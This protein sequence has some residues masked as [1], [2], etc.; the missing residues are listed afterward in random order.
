[1]CPW[2]DLTVNLD[3]KLKEDEAYIHINH[4]PKDMYEYFVR[5]GFIE[6]LN[7]YRQSGFVVFPLCRLN[8]QKFREF[9]IALCITDIHWDT[10][11]D[12]G[13][14][15]EVELPTEVTVPYSAL[16]IDWDP[17]EEEIEDAINNYLSNTYGWLVESYSY[18][19]SQPEED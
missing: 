1:M 11:D 4:V 6:P 17:S 5:E 13:K 14:A 18:N 8:L 10:T 2:V 19:I 15:E 9:E 7:I 16:D 3:A 12:D